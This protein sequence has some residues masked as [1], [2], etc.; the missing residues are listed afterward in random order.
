MTTPS[1]STDTNNPLVIATH[2]GIFH[3]DD[4]FACAVLLKGHPSATIVRTRNG[5]KIESA[6]VVVDVGGVYD[7]FLGRYD[8]HQKGGA[9]A[10]P[11]GIRYSSFGLVWRGYGEAVCASEAV[12]ARV[13]AALVSAVDAVDNG[14]QLMVGGVPAFVGAR[15]IGLSGVIAG[16]N[17]G[18]RH[19]S[20]D[21]DGAFA[22]AVA[23]ASAVL[24]NAIAEASDAETA[25]KLVTEARDAQ[26]GRELLVLDRFIPWQETVVGSDQAPTYVVFPD[27]DGA[28]RVQVVPRAVGEFGAIKDL[29]ITWAGL[30][31]DGFDAV[32]GVP[33]G[34]F[35]HNG[36][37][38]CGHKT[39]EGAIALAELALKS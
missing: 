22:K 5:K 15:P 35:C 26:L 27:I 29:P 1:P 8:H 37:F 21:F 34:I 2:G 30:R 36:R 13:D 38:I 23:F 19:T 31:D 32:T 16:F 3:A 24:D 9:G 17:P 39:R 20:P 6:D 4:V 11:N 14:Q 10:R 25:R 7:P 12:A 18:W 33:G 28:W